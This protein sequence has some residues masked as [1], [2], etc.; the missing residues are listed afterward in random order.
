MEKYSYENREN[1]THTREKNKIRE[2]ERPERMSIVSSMSVCSYGVCIV[3]MHVLRN[4]Q[5]LS[6]IN[7]FK[8]E[9]SQWLTY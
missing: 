3:V 2:T 7:I 6:S 9:K 1:D 4:L 8:V 5:M